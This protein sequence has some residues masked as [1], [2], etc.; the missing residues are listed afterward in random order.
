MRWFDNI[1]VQLVSTFSSPISLSSVKRWNSKNKSHVNVSCPEIAKEYNKSM[2]G[3]DLAD[4]LISLYCT[5]IKTKRW[6]LKLIFHCVD[7]S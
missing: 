2:G 7:I 3:V 6:Y 5:P 4:M 1:C